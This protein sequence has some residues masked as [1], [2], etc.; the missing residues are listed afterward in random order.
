MRISEITDR[1]DGLK[2]AS[3]RNIDKAMIK[4]RQKDPE[5]VVVDANT[6]DLFKHTRSGYSLDLDDPKGGSN[7]IGSR[8]ARAKAHW[9]AG[10]YMDPAEI[11][12]QID[13]R[14]PSVSW[15]DG[16]HR[17][18]AAHQLGHEYGKVVIPRTD[19]EMLKKMV[20]TK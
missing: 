4:Y 11:T 6:Q 14:G 13:N 16:R 9:A 5:Y 1:P 2:W 7:A 8:I 15:Q 17:L 3:G 20:R 18:A 19:L 12:V 10:E